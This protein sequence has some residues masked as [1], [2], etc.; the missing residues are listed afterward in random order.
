MV[1]FFRDNK[2]F[3]LVEI[4]IVIVVIGILSMIGFSS[5]GSVSS[6]AVK[7]VLKN[8][9]DSTKKVIEQDFTKS[10][11][12][13]GSGSAVNGGLG[14][15]SDSN[16][17]QFS[18]LLHNQNYCLS[19]TSK[20]N[21]SIVYNVNSVNGKITSGECGNGGWS[22][23]ASET[24]S[25]C[26]VNLNN[27]IYCWGTNYSGSLANG[28]NGN[29]NLNYL[30]TATL[31]G[32]LPSGAIKQISAG[33]AHYCVIASDDWVYCWGMNSYGGLGDNTTTDK[34]SPVAISRGAIPNGVTIKQL[35]MNPYAN[36]TCA[37]ASNNKAYC[38]GENSDGVLGD[39]TTNEAHVPVE[40]V[41]GAM[42]DQSISYIAIGM[43]H[44]CAINLTNSAAYCWG[45]NW[46][47]EFGNGTSGTQSSIPVAVSQ[48]VM[49]S[50]S[51]VK[52][53]AG[54][55]FT[56]AIA[57]NNQVYCWGW[58]GDILDD[59]GYLGN[60]GSSNS[61]TP[62]AVSK[63][64]RPDLT[65]K[66][67]STGDY[68]TCVISSDD[69]MYCW[70]GGYGGKLGSS[71]NSPKT[72]PTAVNQSS[73]P[74]GAVK[75]IEL[76][77][78]FTCAIASDN[79]IYC[80]GQNDS[81]Q[82]GK[83][84]FS[85]VKSPTMVARGAMPYGTV[86]QVEIGYTHSC[87]IASDD[88]V[89]CWGSNGLGQLGN[90]TYA[91]YKTPV[92]VLQGAMPSLT[93]KKIA[94]GFYHTCVIASN[95]QVYCWGF[96]NKGQL[97][98]GATSNQTV[99][100]AVVTGQMPSLL[101]TQIT[102]GTYSTCVIA[103]SDSRAYCFGSDSYGDLG[104]GKPASSSSTPRQVLAGDMPSPYTV[105][106]ISG[107]VFNACAVSAVNNKEYCWGSNWV[108]LLGVGTATSTYTSPKALAQ[109]AIPGGATILKLGNG[110]YINCSIASD[111]HP[112]CWGFNLGGNVGSGD[113]SSYQINSPAAVLQGGMPSLSLTNVRTVGSFYTCALNL[114][115]KAYCW[116]SGVVD[117]SDFPKSIDLGTMPSS[118]GTTLITGSDDSMCVV[119]NEDLYCWGSNTSGQLG[120][121]QNNGLDYTIPTII[122]DPVGL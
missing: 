9:L 98:N 78:G 84:A 25:S 100:V 101:A 69:K 66:Q 44:T 22:M 64:D 121:D 34:Y 87:A 18:Y 23:I 102:A 94:V 51:V 99:P 68:H 76:G 54:R 58:N 82:L 42:P 13:P 73:M 36:Y 12:Y 3:T 95:N 33:M 70:G 97:G 40:V 29:N 118:D 61:T 30:P 65:A 75:T 45:Y 67:I 2:A 110:G 107:G 6:D 96:G 91:S 103:S 14:L 106:Q 21:N 15:V 93:V 41:K 31:S 62:V 50:T 81:G 79:Y 80:W 88:H 52:L 1:R 60:G 32:A 77:D 119:N 57:S 7:I 53:S 26:A 111:N 89:Y 85:A 19:A 39:S 71:T 8:D 5:Y 59:Y 115:T 109:G 86:K 56:C 10:G 49:P 120:V 104:D 117:G 72:V 43:D 20:K 63:G 122:S 108:G 114:D 28:T 27:K 47:G 48:G 11:S 105:N 112:Y 92:A 116:G 83:G 38:W 37:L 46:K 4:V 90:G 17:T 35:A 55:S 74:W 113:T 24:T 16:V